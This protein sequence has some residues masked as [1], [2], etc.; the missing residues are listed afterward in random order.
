MSNLVLGVIMIV[1]L[2]RYVGL[3]VVQIANIPYE[4]EDW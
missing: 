4:M 2:N 1:E 3:F